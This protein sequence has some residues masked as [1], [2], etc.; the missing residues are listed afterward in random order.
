MT[1][2]PGKVA[3]WSDDSRALDAWIAEAEQLLRRIEHLARLEAPAIQTHDDTQETDQ[4]D[5]GEDD[6]QFNERSL[7]PYAYV[8]RQALFR[9]QLARQRACPDLSLGL[10]IELA[11]AS[12]EA[13]QAESKNW[14]R[15]L[16]E[17]LA[18]EE[19]YSL[20]IDRLLD[21]NDWP[22]DAR[23]E[24]L[25][26]ARARRKQAAEAKK[27]S[28]RAEFDRLLRQGHSARAAAE[29]LGKR[30]GYNPE[31]IRKLLR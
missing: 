20:T 5:A 24:V 30:F 10:I 29:I 22:E 23:L 31:T 13:Q 8:L 21:N 1:G 12:A 26:R 14:I 18:A 11:Q 19:A 28:L 16:E 6:Q 4:P 9:L 27:A 15:E 7:R 17:R 3:D 25:K 2:A